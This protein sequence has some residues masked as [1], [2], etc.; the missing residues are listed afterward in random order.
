MNLAHGSGMATARGGSPTS[1]TCPLDGT[2]FLQATDCV[3]VLFAII[4]VRALLR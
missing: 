4:F 1:T 3:M 2:F